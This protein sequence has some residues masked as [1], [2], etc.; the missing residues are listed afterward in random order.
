MGGANA[1]GSLVPWGANALGS[2]VPWG[3][4]GSRNWCISGGFGSRNWCISG[5]GF[6]LKLVVFGLKMVVFWP[7]NGVFLVD[8]V[9]FLRFSGPLRVVYMYTRR[10]RCLFG[11][12][13]NTPGSQ[14][15]T[16]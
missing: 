9:P 12:G 2:L 10:P 6:C 14:N 1:L 5:G 13:P 11:P 4:F 15:V 3:G 16:F 7:E 8:F